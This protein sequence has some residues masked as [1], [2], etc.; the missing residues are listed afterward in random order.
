MAKIYVFDLDDTLYKEVDFLKSAYG[1]IAVRLRAFGVADAYPK[2]LAW[3]NEG[4]NVFC[5]INEYYGLNIPI[6]DF[7]HW[8]RC[9]VPAISL[10]EGGR[11]LLDFILA[12]GDRVGVITDGRSV[13]QRNKIEALGLS[14]Y[15]LPEDVIISEEFGSEKPNPRNYRYFMGRYP[16]AE[17]IYIADNPSKDFVAANGL[18]W[19]TIGLL[20][21]GRNIHAQE[22]NVT[23]EYMPGHWVKTLIEVIEI[24]T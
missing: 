9:H 10:S 20:D 18:G 17:Y 6:S 13:T 2:M 22:Q 15:L 3:Y 14:K 19:M 5:K 23:Q 11:E 7:L 12:S 8:Y 24:T 21:N 1:E 16:G 4:Q